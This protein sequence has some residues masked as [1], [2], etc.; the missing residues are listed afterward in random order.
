[1]SVYIWAA[2]WDDYS[3]M[4]GPCPKG[5]HVWTK[6]E[7]ELIINSWV[8]FS[9]W[10]TTWWANFSTYLKIPAWWYRT[11]EWASVSWSNDMWYYWTCT[12]Y[13]STY[14][15][16]SNYGLYFRNSNWLS[17]ISVST[18]NWCIWAM[19]R[20]IKD[21]PVEPD[22]SWTTLISSWE[23]WIY[24]SATLWLI[25]MVYSWFVY[26]I[27]DKNVGATTVYNFNDTMSEANCWKFFQMWNNYQFP[28]S[29]TLTTSSTQVN[30]SNYWPG[31]YYSSSTFIT[32]SSWWDSSQNKD[33][34]W[35]ETWVQQTPKE[36]KSA[37]LGSYPNDEYIE[38]K[39]RAS[40]EW[41]VCIPTNWTNHTSRTSSTVWADYNWKIYLDWSYVATVT[42]TSYA[43]S[44]RTLSGW[45]TAWQ[46]YTVRIEPVTIDYWRALAFSFMNLSSTYRDLVTEVVHWNTYVWY[47]LSATNTG[48][49]F[50]YWIFY[51]CSNLTN[52]DDEIL[53]N[54][55]K[56]IWTNFRSYEYG[57]CTSL[58]KAAKEA[59][60]TATTS[61]WEYYRWYQ[62]MGSENIVE[63]PCW[64][65]GTAS[66]SNYR[67]SQFYHCDKNKT[68]KVYSD[69][70]PN[71][72]SSALIN[73]YVT[74]VYVPSAYLNNYK[75]ATTYP[76]SS[77]DDS[78]F[79]WY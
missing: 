48:N 44:I 59:Y 62:Y 32:W 26:T 36:L 21:V 4:R 46:E 77:I 58:T 68:V 51:S 74:T 54:T 75:N 50:R 47:A 72:I 29:W 11:W 6:S 23:D 43:G 76:W 3:A 33:L 56:T 65:D 16:Y 45:L 1:M 41:K 53:P 79:T 10:N 27:A 52:I 69:V 17:G 5:F 19:I 55:V 63:V 9:A 12:Q 24:H 18:R 49:Y 8:A 30:A 35:W 39:I 34:W 15:T 67:I 14:N 70:W 61:I 66:G 73:D 2:T 60:S 57:F 7:W 13:N 28:Y 22:S 20:W 42:W 25:S 38:Y 31:N 40:S 37:Y 71:T 64:I 78:K